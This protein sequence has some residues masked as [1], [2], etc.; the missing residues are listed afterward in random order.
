MGWEINRV[1][2]SL[3][4]ERS[5]IIISI[6][7]SKST[8]IAHFQQLNHSQIIAEAVAHEIILSFSYFDKTLPNS[9]SQPYSNSF[10]KKIKQTN[11]YQTNTVR[12]IQSG[13]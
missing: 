10:R 4:I 7:L 2:H 5:C 1:K 8:T 6:L 3:T 13:F 9:K 12:K 11:A